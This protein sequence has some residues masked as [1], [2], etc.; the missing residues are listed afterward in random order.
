MKVLFS[1]G[2]TGGSVTP[3]LAL[4]SYLDNYLPKAEKI[5]IG[6]NYGPENELVKSAGIKFLTIDSGK[7]RRYADWNN[8]IDPFRVLHGLFQALGILRR[9]RPSVIIG[10]GGYV[11]VPVIWAGWLLGIPSVIHQPDVIVGLANKLA[12]PFASRITVGFEVSKNIFNSEKVKYTGNPVRSDILQGSREHALSL[13]GLNRKLKTILVIGGGT[14]A[15][16]LNQLIASAALRLVNFYQII[17]L[18]GRGKGKFNILNPNYHQYEFLVDEQKHALAIADLVISRA[19]ISTLSELAALGK[20][21]ILVPLPSSHQMVNAEYFK[22]Q[23]AA[24]VLREA[25]LTDVK[26][27]ENIHELLSNPDHLGSLS[28]NMAKLGQIN[29]LE[30]I[31][32]VILQV[33]KEQ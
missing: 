20:A 27:V 22:K 28:L 29:A 16:R 33:I 17:H 4:A 32:K 6:T 18:T 26:I 25:D 2:G 7:L 13:F 10:A 19:G 5:F 23:N 11:S 1:G 21:S 30:N 31:S 9:I 24:V 3:L 8:L 12:K 14:G 15:L